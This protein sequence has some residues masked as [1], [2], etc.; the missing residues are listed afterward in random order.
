MKPLRPHNGTISSCSRWHR[1]GSGFTLIELVISVALGA[2]VLGSAYLCLNAGFAAQNLLEPRVDTFQSARVAMDLICA[3]LRCA[4]PFAS[5]PEFIGFRRTLGDV[6]AD[7]LDFATRNYTPRTPG[8]GDYCEQSLYLERNPKSGE[9]SLMRRR[10]PKVAF[11]PLVGGTREEIA[12]GVAGFRLEYYDG[13]EWFDTWGEPNPGSRTAPAA[14]SA[15]GSILKPNAAG[16]PEAVRVTLRFHPSSR[17]T[18]PTEP[19]LVYQSVVRIAVPFRASGGATLSPTGT[20]PTGKP[21][22]KP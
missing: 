3:D 4:C 12:T 13:F 16:L 15:A 6:E 5:G 14:P 22:T 17:K 19:P 21:S 18:S 2:L 9:F 20:P 1:S 8:Q 10:N 11:D 7:N